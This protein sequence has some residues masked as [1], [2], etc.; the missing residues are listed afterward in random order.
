MSKV[1]LFRGRN[2]TANLFDNVNKGVFRAAEAVG[3]SA[4]VAGGHFPFSDPHVSQ[5]KHQPA[6]QPILIRSFSVA[7]C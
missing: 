3:A 5:A 1:T 2:S 4:G 6:S 7:S